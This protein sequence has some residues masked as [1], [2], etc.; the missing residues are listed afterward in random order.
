VLQ[1]CE[2]GPSRLVFFLLLCLPRLGPRSLSVFR[3]LEGQGYPLEACNQTHN[4]ASCCSM[5]V[6][7]VM[8]PPPLFEVCV[9]VCLESRW[10]G[11]TPGEMRGTLSGLRDFPRP[12]LAASFSCICRLAVSGS[13][14]YYPMCPAIRGV[15]PTFPP[16]YRGLWLSLLYPS[17]HNCPT[18]SDPMVTIIHGPA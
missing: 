2:T 5:W 9:W 8:I 3:T 6:S 14:Y 4:R 17:T 7:S 12:S 11:T 18:N 10:T 13:C 1:I 15:P 16:T